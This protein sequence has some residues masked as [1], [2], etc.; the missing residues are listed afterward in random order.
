MILSTSLGVLVST[1]VLDEDSTWLTYY[2]GGII[3]LLVSSVI[4]EIRNVYRH[5]KELEEE[6]KKLKFE[7]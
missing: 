2:F 4:L 5:R 7:F 1:Y 3:G 6:R